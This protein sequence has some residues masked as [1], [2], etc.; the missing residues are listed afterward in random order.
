M[1]ARRAPLTLSLLLCA[2]L[3]ACANDPADTASHDAVREAVRSIN[4]TAQVDSITPSPIPGLMEVRAAGAVVYISHDGG[5]VLAGDLYD[6]KARQN[7]TEQSRQEVRSDILATVDKDSRI[8][9]GP[10]DAAHTL[11]VFT[12]ISCPYCTQLHEDVPEL[13]RLGVAVEYLAYPR[14]GI[15][16]GP[17]QVMNGA[18]CA[19]DRNAALDAAFAGDGKPGTGCSQVLRKHVETARL[20]EVEGTPTIYTIDGRQ[21]GGY[22]P[23]A[24]LLKAIDG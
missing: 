11:Y 3:P 18:W 2:A 21:L 24:E 1:T 16:S 12:D 20:L 9:F 23:P 19:D 7:L 6:V 5:H 22:L 4:P 17:G 10:A 15:Q 14:A 8:R 13:N